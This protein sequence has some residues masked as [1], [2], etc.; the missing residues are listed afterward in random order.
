MKILFRRKPF[1]LSRKI[2]VITIN[3]NT[4]MHFYALDSIGHVVS[5]D[6]AIRGK[7]YKCLECGGILRVRGGIH[8]RYHYY[9]L[10]S[11]PSCLRSSGKSAAHRNLQHRLLSLFPTEDCS[12]ERSFPEI[13]RIADVVVKKH[14]LVFEVQCSPISVE[15]VQR[16]NNDYSSME[17]T[18]VW[19]L[20]DALY[21]R[22]KVSAA[23]LFLQ[24]RPHYFFCASPRNHGIIYDSH[25]VIIENLRH[26]IVK[27]VA[28]DITKPL[29]LSPATKLHCCNE[30][31]TVI[32]RRAKMWPVCFGD[33]LVDIF[34]NGEESRASVVSAT[35]CAAEKRHL[36]RYKRTTKE[37][38][39]AFINAAIFLT[40]I[41]PYRIF[42]RMLL[43]KACR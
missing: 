13:G 22:K 10:S 25:A 5:A 28:I 41:K 36:A 3:N 21:N 38:V 23:E 33:D 8:R 26:T 39:W 19:L 30:V 16:R 6:H 7:D 27:S 35:I 1:F 11:S 14:R 42:F 31:P 12:L 32:R 43:E 9:H 29:F 40:I 15:E 17:Y 18:V 37:K 20:S 4:Y 2:P 34:I 24:D